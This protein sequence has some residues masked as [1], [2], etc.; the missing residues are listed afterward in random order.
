MK[1]GP[2]AGPAGGGQLLNIIIVL[3]ERPQ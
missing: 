2:D 1:P 3:A